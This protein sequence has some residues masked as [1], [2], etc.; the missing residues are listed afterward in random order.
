M[1]S[2]LCHIYL[3]YICEGLFV[4]GN[5]T[6]SVQWPYPRG[7]STIDTPYVIGDST[8]G[9]CLNWCIASSYLLSIPL[10]E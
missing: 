4:D 7:D 3:T 5:M 2:S 10:R 9:A 6:D 8:H 1:S